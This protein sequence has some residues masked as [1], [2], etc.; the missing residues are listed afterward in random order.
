MMRWSFTRVDALYLEFPSDRGLFFHSGCWVD[1]IPGSHFGVGPRGDCAPVQ[2]FR[3]W[4]ANWETETI[5]ELTIPDSCTCQE[6]CD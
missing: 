3:A 1:S 5:T 2:P 4:G 6:I